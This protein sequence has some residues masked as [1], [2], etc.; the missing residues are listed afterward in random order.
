MV[1]RIN[2]NNL[3]RIVIT[4]LLSGLGP[5]TGGIALDTFDGKTIV[6]AFKKD[7]NYVTHEY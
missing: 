7:S 4:L 5:R 6:V 3:K 2:F 1:V